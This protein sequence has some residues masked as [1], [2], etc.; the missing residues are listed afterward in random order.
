[1]PVIANI[2]IFCLAWLI[3][4]KV[5]INHEN[6]KEVVYDRIDLI[7]PVKREEMLEHLKK[8]TGLNLHRIEFSTIAF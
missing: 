6:H 4:H 3:D 2:L 5:R 8:R 1:L 7:T